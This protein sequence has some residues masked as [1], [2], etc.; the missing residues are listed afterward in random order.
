MIRGREGDR[1]D[2]GV[3]GWNKE[4]KE[5]EIEIERDREIEKGGKKEMVAE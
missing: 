5:T 3:E 4:G 1:R 2:G